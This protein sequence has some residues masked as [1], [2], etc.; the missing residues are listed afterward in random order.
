MTSLL[1]TPT[2][3][4]KTQAKVPLGAHCTTRCSDPEKLHLWGFLPVYVFK[5]PPC[6]PH[7]I[8]FDLLESGQLFFP[9]K[10][11]VFQ[12]GGYNGATL[13]NTFSVDMFSGF[14]DVYAVV[15]LLSV[16]ELQSLTFLRNRQRALFRAVVLSL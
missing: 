16:K 4:W 15:E 6:P 1:G 14:L 9:L 5:T 13:V 12:F 11:G 10:E 7:P 2:G 8:L 3:A